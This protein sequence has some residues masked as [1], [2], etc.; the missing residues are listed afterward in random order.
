MTKGVDTV[1][2]PS[3]RLF[4]FMTNLNK[5]VFFTVFDVRFGLLRIFMAGPLP[6]WTP[7]LDE[8]A[9]LP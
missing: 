1:K 2:L 9:V 5:V 8:L 4:F 6:S 3:A 7:C